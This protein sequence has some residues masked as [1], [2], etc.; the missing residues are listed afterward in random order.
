MGDTF[1]LILSGDVSMLE[2]L[3]GT[4][5]YLGMGDGLDGGQ[6]KE[7]QD[8]YK[9]LIGELK[10]SLDIKAKEPGDEL[11]DEHQRLLREHLAEG[12]ARKKDKRE[13]KA[14]ELGREEGADQGGNPGARA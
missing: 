13:K 1:A 7:I 5:G 4:D 14:G 10:Q 3:M 6:W 12:D 2:Q 11:F 8:A 9:E